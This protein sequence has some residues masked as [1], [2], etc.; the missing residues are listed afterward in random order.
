MSRYGRTVC[1]AFCIALLAGTG[2]RAGEVAHLALDGNLLDPVGGND[3]SVVGGGA[4]DFVEGHDGTAG[5]AV[6]FVDGDGTV[7]RLAHTA[8]LPLN[9]HTAFS[10]AMWV[11]GP[12]QRDKRVFSEGSTTNGTPLFNLGT[13]NSGANGAL[14]AF[15]RPAS[16]TRHVYSTT[17]VFDDTWH[18]IASVSYTHLTLP[19]IYSV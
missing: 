2:A 5:G 10:I 9:N 16:P 4:V 18:H 13:H 14:D 15:I 6:R 17:M 1:F 11:R 12:A 3:G 19:T 8:G 7:V